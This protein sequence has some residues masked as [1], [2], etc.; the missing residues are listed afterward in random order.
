MYKDKC[1]YENTYNITQEHIFKHDCQNS[2]EVALF[3]YE[4]HGRL[5]KIN[6]D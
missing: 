5:L 4:P 3:L 2:Y 6:F 1:L